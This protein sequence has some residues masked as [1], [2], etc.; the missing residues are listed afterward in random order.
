MKKKILIA[1][2]TGFIGT[3]L[4]SKCIEKKWIVDILSHK[5]KSK[6]KSKKN[7]KHIVCDITNFKKLKKKVK[8]DYDYVINLSGYIDHSSKKKL[9]W[10]ITRAVKI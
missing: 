7:I 9:F 10:F 3:H 1:G 6:F 2:G 4:A 5:K 8:P